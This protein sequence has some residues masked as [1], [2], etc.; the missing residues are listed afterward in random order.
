[1][2]VC[3]CREIST[4]QYTTEEALKERIM[5]NDFKCGICLTKYIIEEQLDNSDQAVN[6]IA[7]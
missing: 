2:I 3:S 7:V 4:R 5:Q 1:M 6:N